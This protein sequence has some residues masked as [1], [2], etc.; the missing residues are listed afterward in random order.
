MNELLNVEV[1]SVTLKM[2]GLAWEQTL[3]AME[4]EPVVALL[5]GAYY[6]SP[7]E[8]DPH[9]ERFWP[10]TIRI[11][12]TEKR[13]RV[14]TKLK[15]MVTDIL[16]YQQKEALIFQEEK[17]LV[18][19]RGMPAFPSKKD[20]CDGKKGDCRRWTNKSSCP[21]RSK[22]AFEHDDRN[23]GRGDKRQ[24][25]PTPPN[26]RLPSPKPEVS[27]LTGN[28]P[29]ERDDRL[30]RYNCNGEG[31]WPERRQFRLLAPSVLNIS[32]KKSVQRSRQCPF[33]HLSKD[34]RHS[35]AK[36][37]AQGDTVKDSSA[38]AKQTK[39]GETLCKSL[40][41]SKKVLK[42]RETSSAMGQQK[43]QKKVHWSDYDMKV[44][45]FRE[46]IRGRGVKQTM[47]GTKACQLLQNLMSLAKIDV[48]STNFF[49]RYSGTKE[50]TH[51]HHRQ[52]RSWSRKTGCTL[53]TVVLLCI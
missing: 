1:R 25:T 39:E 8:V 53:S 6:I 31:E 3:M 15:A 36:R 51:T 43:N 28:I 34:D 32:E 47:Y 52:T 40:T 5:E 38:I 26:R 7:I 27:N 19:D 2:F 46:A 30:P 11:K 42:L 21:R 10:H 44:A 35:S 22:C 9:E 13:Q 48:H 41:L 16:E 12:F 20:K 29:S 17:S 4:L 33:V 50:E 37:A 49:K 45:Y 23:R 18:K 14:N 24:R